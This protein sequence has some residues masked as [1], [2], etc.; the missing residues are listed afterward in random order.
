MGWGG[1]RHLNPNSCTD[2][3]TTFLAMFET[4][5]YLALKLASLALLFY[6]DT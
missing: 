5:E 1:V 3:L 6:A 4:D 2:N